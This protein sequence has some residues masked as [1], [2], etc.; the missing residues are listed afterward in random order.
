V[1]TVR[2]LLEGRGKVVSIAAGESVQGAVAALTQH[3]ISAL[4]VMEDDVLV[5]I[6]TERDVV[7]RAYS[8]TARLPAVLR[9]R[10]IMTREL[11]TVGPEHSIEDCMA[12]MIDHHVR[13]LPVVVAGHAVGMLS[14]RDLVGHVLSEKEFVIRQMTNY[15]SGVLE[16]PGNP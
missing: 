8:A 14:M 11:I 2:R 1:T 10:D 6:L 5:G 13:H 12:L 16:A 4:A 9:V 15:I 3:D 7:R